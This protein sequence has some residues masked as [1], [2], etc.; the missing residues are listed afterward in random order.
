MPTFWYYP[1]SVEKSIDRRLQRL[2]SESPEH[3]QFRLCSMPEA[4]ST[5]RTTRS[6]LSDV[7]RDSCAILQ[8]YRPA[9]CAKPS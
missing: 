4:F 1:S 2:I 3:E 9:A 8:V 7:F 6:L 5:D